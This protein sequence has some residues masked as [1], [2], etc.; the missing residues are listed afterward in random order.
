M[1]YTALLLLGVLLLVWNAGALSLNFQN[2]SDLNSIYPTATYSLA[3][4]S[5]VYVYQTGSTTGG[6]QYMYLWGQGNGFANV[7]AYP[8]SYIAA[9]VISKLY[10][11]TIGLYDSSKNSLNQIAVSCN[12]GQRF[13]LIM[14]SGSIPYTYCN[15]VSYGSYS[16]LNQNPSYWNFYSQYSYG[17]AGLDD[18]VIGNTDSPYVYGMPQA[19]IFVIQ[20]DFTNSAASGFYFY[21][22]TAISSNNMTTTFS[23]NNGNNET[24]Y[25]AN[26][27]TGTI[28]SSY[29]TGTAY[30]GSIAWNL[31]DLFD[32]SAPMGRYRTYIEG[33][34]YSD[35]IFYIGA[36]AAINFNSHT[37]SQGDQAA[38]SYAVSTGAYWNTQ[39]YNYQVVVQD[40]YGNVKQTTSLTTQTGSVTYTWKTT[41]DPNVYYAIIQAV[42]KTTGNVVWMNYDYTNLNAYTTFRG[43]VHDGYNTLPVA[44]ANV[45]INQGAVVSNSITIADGNYTATGFYSGATTN[46]N[47]TA[48]GYKQYQAIITPM[49]S[50]MPLNFTIYPLSPSVTGAAI[51]GVVRTG[52][53]GADNLTITQGYGE[54]IPF[55][56][57]YFTNTTTGEKYYTISN[58]VGGYLVDQT[59][60]A[61]V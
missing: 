50:S 23:K 24:V 36:G 53:L 29:N 52:V 28:Y 46:I 27:D 30:T 55:A 11:P 43:F 44:N 13:E 33:H 59:H 25:L 41:D 48:A 17:Y 16:V 49:S 45:S 6:N 5:S 4:G 9:T 10:A 2:P 39:L 32:K 8:T 12:V 58:S 21:N 37:Y 61:P 7:V 18:I 14:S 15:G 42:D 40:I 35:S 1:R 26:T 34:G 51:G 22:G 57:V 47:V 54:P 3:Q 60:G 20:R 19:N 31:H 56:T 38:I